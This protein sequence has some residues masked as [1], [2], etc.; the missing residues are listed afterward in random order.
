MGH[1]LQAATMLAVALGATLGAASAC[2]IAAGARNASPSGAFDVV[3]AEA[4]DA[5]AT[6]DVP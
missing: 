1:L 5:A 3:D 2:Q 4:R 6:T